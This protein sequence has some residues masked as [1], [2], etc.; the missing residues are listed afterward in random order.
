[1]ENH[2]KRTNKLGCKNQVCVENQ[3]FG[4]T[5]KLPYFSFQFRR[6]YGHET[7]IFFPS[8]WHAKTLRVQLNWR[9]Y[10][11]RLRFRN[12]LLSSFKRRRPGRPGST[13]ITSRSVLWGE[14]QIILCMLWKRRQRK[15]NVF[16]DSVQFYR[17]FA[18]NIRLFIIFAHNTPSIRASSLGTIG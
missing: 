16:L 3:L 6:D 12:L 14:P 5:F 8:I 1:M 7:T 2:K 17:F 18:V 4:N 10:Q 9:F 15:E 13:W 11:I